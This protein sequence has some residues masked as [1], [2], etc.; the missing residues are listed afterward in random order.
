MKYE[1]YIK[2]SEDEQKS[3]FDTL[4]DND[5]TISDLTAERDSLKKELDEKNIFIEENKK[6]LAA[7][8]ELNFSLAR[9][10][11]TSKSTKSFEET[12]HDCFIGGNKKHDD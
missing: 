10:I 7:T 9:K 8:K 3:F 2:L 4:S 5:K 12:L 1:D 11:D 6:E